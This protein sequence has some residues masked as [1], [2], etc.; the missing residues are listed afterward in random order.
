[1]LSHSQTPLVLVDRVILGSAGALIM[2]VGLYF[3][4]W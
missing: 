4:F 3:Q 1:M 2:T